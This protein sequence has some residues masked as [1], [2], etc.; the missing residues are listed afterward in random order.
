[1]G[2]HWQ[3]GTEVTLPPSREPAEYQACHRSPEAELCTLSC[4]WEG[5]AAKAWQVVLCGRKRG[6]GSESY[7]LLPL[8]GKVASMVEQFNL[9]T[10]R[11]ASQLMNSVEI[12]S[13]VMVRHTAGQRPSQALSGLLV[14]SPL[15]GP[16]PTAEE[17]FPHGTTSSGRTSPVAGDS[18]SPEH[19][20]RVSGLGEGTGGKGEHVQ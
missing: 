4:G 10:T 8:A 18:S 16:Q 7:W 12:S 14:S 3:A 20:K 11:S 13:P 2:R 6:H 15:S 17:E 19:H 9:R 5:W 1:M